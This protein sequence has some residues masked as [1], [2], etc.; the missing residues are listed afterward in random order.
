M[1]AIVAVTLITVAFASLSFVNRRPIA[2]SLGLLAAAVPWTVLWAGPMTCRD[3]DLECG[4]G[5]LVALVYTA[6][7][8]LGLGAVAAVGAF[9]RRPAPFGEVDPTNE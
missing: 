5:V 8:I 3:H 1:W 6:P 7:V 2:G 4:F 9:R